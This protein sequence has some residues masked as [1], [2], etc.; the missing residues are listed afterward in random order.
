MAIISYLIPPIPIPTRNLILTTM[1]SATSI[2]TPALMQPHPT[3]VPI[4][5]SLKMTMTTTMMKKK[6]A[7]MIPTSTGYSSIP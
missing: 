7:A 6:N 2:R 3:N 1:A 4:P 5:T